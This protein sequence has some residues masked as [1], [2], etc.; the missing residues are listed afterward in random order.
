[1]DKRFNTRLGNTEKRSS[2][3]MGDLINC[4]SKSRDYG[5][6]GQFRNSHRS[7]NRRFAGTGRNL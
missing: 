3:R 1:M 7:K 6:P 4:S 2:G 5:P